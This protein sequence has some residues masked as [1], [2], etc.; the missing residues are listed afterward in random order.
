[1]GDNREAL[2]TLFFWNHGETSVF[3]LLVNTYSW[4]CLAYSV[5]VGLNHCEM[6][7]LMH[8]IRKESRSLKNT[9]DVSTKG[10]NVNKQ[11]LMNHKLSNQW[12]LI[13][14]ADVIRAMTSLILGY[15][16]QYTEYSKVKR[17]ET[18]AVLKG[19]PVVTIWTMLIR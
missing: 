6:W 12:W 8:L 5:Y 3:V 10:R 15:S 17:Y 16:S 19:R 1:M 18:S 13:A 11:A 4:C 14:V 9:Y 2:L 7:F